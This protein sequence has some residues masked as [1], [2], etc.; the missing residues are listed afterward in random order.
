MRFILSVFLF[1]LLVQCNRKPDILEPHQG[2]IQDI[3]NNRDGFYY[4]ERSLPENRQDLAIGVFDSGIGGLSV[5][6][7][8]IKADN[9]NV[10]Q[11]PEPD[12]IRDFSGEKFVYL[13]DQ[14]NM[15][16]SNYAETGRT[17]LLVEHILKDAV[18][19]VNNRYHN[20]PGS[21]QVLHDK[22]RVKSIVIAC[23]TA[24]AFGQAQIEA[25]FEKTGMNI[26]V[27]GVI[28]SGAKGALALLGKDEE[29]VIAVFA[30]PATVK[31]GAYVEALED[32]IAA[33]HYN[34]RIEIIQQGG[35]G[36]HE[37]ID[38]KPGFIKE[39][40]K[41]T[42]P[43]YQG[44]SY[45]HPQYKIERSL[46][47][48]YHFDTTSSHLLYNR[49]TLQ[50]SDTIQLNSIENYVRYHLVTLV[51]KIRESGAD[52]PLRSIVL[53]CTH[54][55]FVIDEITEVLDELRGMERYT[56]LLPDQIALIDPAENS[57]VELYSH[58]FDGG[59]LNRESGGP[60]CTSSFFISVPNRSLPGSQVTREGSFDYEY[61]YFGR[62][63]NDLKNSTLI[64]PFSRE[65]IS[66]GQLQQ[67]ERRFPETYRLITRPL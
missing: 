21:D 47:P 26:Y 7:A 5:F 22:P 10:R 29:G 46:L 44:P 17:E 48:A 60:G 32:Q 45:S 67:I 35:K 12:G 63:A 39:V 40:A 37:S 49:E 6:D 3:L 25:L 41:G 34:G 20:S 16:Y 19:L 59:L 43:A 28:D 53:G 31:S 23:N 30:T 15:P 58:L 8:I 61:Q 57:A 64:I 51:E 24:T 2:F 55:P 13:A 33:G 62:E 27:I 66:D 54:Y 14:A 9:F 42:Y 36:L 11:E 4:L 50:L 1:F 38:H 52:L 56:P 65:V 18:F